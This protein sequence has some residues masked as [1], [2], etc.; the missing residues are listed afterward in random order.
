MERREQVFVSST[1][2]DLRE[3]RQAVI[4]G[5]LE[6][7]CIPAG[8]ELFPA[9]DSDKWSLI[10]GVINDSDY[11]LLIIGGRYGS[12]DPESDLSYT[13]MEFDY[14][15][16]VGKPI[17]AFLHGETGS[18]SADKSELNPSMR[19]KLDAFRAK[20]EQRMVKYWTTPEELDGAVAKS[21]IKIRKTHPAEGW[22]RANYAMTPEVERD[23]AELRAKVSELTQQLEAERR[24]SKMMVPEGLAEGD[25]IYELSAQIAFWKIDDKDEPVY[26][27]KEYRTTIEIPATWN[28][29]LSRLGPALLDEATE[30]TIKSELNNLAIDTLGKN[31]EFLPDGLGGLNR[32][33]IGAETLKDIVVQL[34]A[35]DLIAHGS[36]RRPVSDRATYWRLTELGCDK[37]M[38]LRAIRR[39]DENNLDSR[40]MESGTGTLY[41]GAGRL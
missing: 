40:T 7:D 32:I 15:V 5:L 2:L 21:L 37:M 4:Q 10:Q 31:R 33:D 26:R 18:I 1:Y 38:I 28:G 39:S 11:Y 29:I 9:S 17:M 12:V 23:I 30:Q 16:G 27:R 14:A 13:E 41:N 8:M 34:F 36:K 19:V 35:L 6:A 25:D 20:A 24:S 3:E 22:V